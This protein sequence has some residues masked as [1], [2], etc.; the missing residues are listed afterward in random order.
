MRV[1]NKEPSMPYTYDPPLTKAE[2][3]LATKDMLEDLVYRTAFLSPIMID[4]YIER[5]KDIWAPAHKY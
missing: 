5:L 3:Q 4:D 1:Y 2:Q